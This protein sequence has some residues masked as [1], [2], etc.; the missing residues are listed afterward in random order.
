MYRNHSP[1]LGRQT[2]ACLSLPATLWVALLPDM[3]RFLTQKLRAQSLNEVQPYEPKTEAQ[4]SDY[5]TDSEEENQEV[6]QFLEERKMCNGSSNPISSPALITPHPVRLRPLEDIVNSTENILTSDRDRHSSEEE[7]TGL[8]KQPT[9]EKRKWSQISRG[10]NGDVSGSSDEEVKELCAKPIPLRFSASPPRH[11]Q[12]LTR[13]HS[14]GNATFFVANVG[15]AGDFASPRK[16]HRHAY[17]LDDS[18]VQNGRCLDFEKMQQKQ[19]FKR[20]LSHGHGVRAARM[21]RIKLSMGEAQ[22][23]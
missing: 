9:P 2:A 3:L 4:D 16:R 22:N 14:E 10:G 8:D 7:L 11:L 17:H 20:F 1:R 21:V 6:E 23:I 5:N 19:C 15:P 13:K 12:R 18:H